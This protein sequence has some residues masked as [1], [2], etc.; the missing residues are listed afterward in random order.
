MLYM[1]A[2][3]A[4]LEHIHNYS[5]TSWG[6]YKELVDKA[7]KYLRVVQSMARTPEGRVELYE[8]RAFAWHDA[9]AEWCN[10]N[11]E[12]R[13]SDDGTVCR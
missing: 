13:I 5:N 6:K 3:T 2:E 10:N 11:Q 12:Y 7:E 9:K 8:A 4:F 1:R